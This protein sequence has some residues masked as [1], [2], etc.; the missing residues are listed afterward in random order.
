MKNN[1]ELVSKLL[2]TENSKLSNIDKLLITLLMRGE[3]NLNELNNF[4][5]PKK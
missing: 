2:G 4:L 5:K 3:V 1:C